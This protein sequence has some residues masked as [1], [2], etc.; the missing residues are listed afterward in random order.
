MAFH[1]PLRRV[2]LELEYAEYEYEQPDW[3]QDPERRT[4]LLQVG[5]LLGRARVYLDEER[6]ERLAGAEWD[7]GDHVFRR[8]SLWLLRCRRK[9]EFPEHGEWAS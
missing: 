7:R 2:A 8:V 4:R 1:I 3:R 6:I 5:V 9:G